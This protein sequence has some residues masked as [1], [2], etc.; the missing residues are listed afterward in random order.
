[1][2][3]NSTSATMVKLQAEVQ[4]M[5]DEIDPVS[6]W[7]LAEKRC[8]D[9]LMR[10]YQEFIDLPRQHPDE[11]RDFVDP[12]HRLQDLL[13]VRIV[14]R[15]FPQGWPTHDMEGTS[16]PDKDIAIGAAGTRNT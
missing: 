13:A 4:Q 1:M 16:C 2:S 15:V 5:R 6:G 12:L 3:G 9:A 7:T 11:M 8:H 14:R 10:A